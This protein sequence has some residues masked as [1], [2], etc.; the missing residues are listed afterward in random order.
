MSRFG[1]KKFTI[2]GKLIDS[3]DICLCGFLRQKSLEFFYTI[4]VNVGKNNGESDH[5]IDPFLLNQ[6]YQLV[7]TKNSFKLR[8][9]MANKSSTTS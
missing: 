8:I 7:E 4:A 1:P 2:E 3:F 9:E 6:C 5:N